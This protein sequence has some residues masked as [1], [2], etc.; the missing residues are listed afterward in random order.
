MEE[1][2][3]IVYSI[4]T[5]G[6]LDEEVAAA[7]RLYLEELAN[8]ICPICHK[9]AESEDQVG[10]CVYARPCGHRMFQGKARKKS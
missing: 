4:N 8:H 6:L 9:P 7:A 2:Q 5:N 10:R 1:E 3:D